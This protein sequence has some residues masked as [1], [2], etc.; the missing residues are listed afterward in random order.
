MG[1]F[2]PGLVHTEIDA[3]AKNPAER[4]TSVDLGG[5]GRARPNYRRG[6]GWQRGQ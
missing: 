6:R 4:G 3:S 5:V 2:L 1:F